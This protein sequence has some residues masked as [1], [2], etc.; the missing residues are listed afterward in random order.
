MK[1]RVFQSKVMP[2]VNE[3]YDVKAEAATG[4]G[5]SAAFLL[6]IINKL[7]KL[8]E[9][10]DPESRQ[11]KVSA[12][13]VEPTRELVDQI[14]KEAKMF[15]TGTDVSVNYT[16][17]KIDMRFTRNSLR[18]DGCDILIG[19]PGRLSHLI[20]DGTIDVADLKFLVIDEADDLLDESFE[21][22]MQII[23]NR[24]SKVRCS[25]SFFKH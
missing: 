4:C 6:P 2:I 17:G 1:P 9:G 7:S 3:G 5:K 23:A 18:T 24:L 20:D 25:Q 16:F 14:Q 21:R 11:N 15:A 13:I 22:D 19:S 8:F 10:S 12:L